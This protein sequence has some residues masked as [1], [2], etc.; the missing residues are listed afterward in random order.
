MKNTLLASRPAALSFLLGA[1]LFT[2][3]PATLHAQNSLSSSEVIGVANTQYSNDVYN[4]DSNFS[5]TGAFT[6]A[7]ANPAFTG[8]DGRGVIQTMNFDGYASSRAAYGQLHL[9]ARGSVYNTY[10]NSANAPYY[11]ANTGTVDPGGSPDYLTAASFAS[12]R[13]TL[14]YGG[15]LQAGYRARYFFHVDGTNTGTNALEYLFVNIAGNQESFYNFNPGSIDTVYATRDY[16]INGQTPQ[17]ISVTF[18]AQFSFNVNSVNDGTNVF[19]EANFANT[20]SL[21]GIQI[22]D[23]NGNPV[24]GVTFTSGSG[25]TY[26]TVVPEPGT[27][28]SAAAGGALLWAVAGRRRRGAR[29][30]AG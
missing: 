4:L 2:V 15:E 16:L 24:S 5:G 30:V 14:Q 8:L 7:T 13:D 9:Y 28:A 21:A 12:F 3:R 17:T 20:A 6:S 10:Y 19:G 27:L 23:A 1:A 26:Q 29:A 11:N 25:T 18:S 22:V